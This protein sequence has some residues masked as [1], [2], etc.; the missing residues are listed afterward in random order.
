MK[1]NANKAQRQQGDVLLEKVTTIPKG[2]KRLGHL[3]LAEGEV[4]GHK[5][6]IALTGAIDGGV[7]TL[8]EEKGNLYLS[9]ENGE[10][11]LTH[12]EHKPLTLEEGNYFVGRVNEYDYETEEAK[13]VAD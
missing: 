4:T 11:T 10:V 8:F 9:V 13:K 5:H 6:E 1:K 7:A 2:A 12:Q 3:V